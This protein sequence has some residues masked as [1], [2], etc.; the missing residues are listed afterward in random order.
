MSP[1][2]GAPA[3]ALGYDVEREL[4]PVA[5]MYR[6]AYRPY[7]LGAF[8]LPKENTVAEWLRDQECLAWTKDEE[9]WGEVVAACQVVFPERELP[10]R[11]F[12]GAVR[13][14]I[15]ASDVVVRHPAATTAQG[16]D[17]LTEFLC[18]QAPL[19]EGKRRWLEGWQESPE[20]R[21]LAEAAG[22]ERKA[23]KIKASS[24]LVTVWGPPGHPTERPAPADTVTLGRLMVPLP[25]AG[26]AV[27]EVAD[28][29]G[30]AD[31]YSSYNAKHAW[32]ALSL[33]GYVEPG[34]EPSA[35]EIVKPSEM[36]KA[37]KALHPDWPTWPV[38]PTPL[39]QELPNVAAL[40]ATLGYVLGTTF[41]R[42]RLM[43]LQP[44][45]GELTRHSD[46]TD[47][48]AGT[49]DG[50]LARLHVPLITNPDVRFRQWN[51]E[52][53]QVEAHM[54]P[55]ECWYLDTRKPHKAGNYGTSERIHLVMDAY[56]N[57][58]LR[59][60]IEQAQEAPEVAP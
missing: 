30:W 5:R 12:T 40:V 60:H 43:R 34:T 2:A 38:A 24:E 26:P 55:G 32:S 10:V 15:P 23:T 19:I 28:Q 7:V 46:I 29:H 59:E 22:L 11:D 13:T 50:K 18:G 16:W 44:G 9:P 4:R 52:G 17:Y 36:S 27:L 58:R 53:R 3:W 39:V 51:L 42:V 35:T 37:W 8:G 41:Q 33:Q 14:R 47:P 45:G 21:R 1:T 6:E 56:V 49:A 20:I 25:Q 48:E 31:H 57:A 54:G